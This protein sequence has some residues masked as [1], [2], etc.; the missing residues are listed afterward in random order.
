METPQGLVPFSLRTRYNPRIATMYQVYDIVTECETEVSRSDY[1][2][3][4][5]DGDFYAMLEHLIAKNNLWPKFTK[6]LVEYDAFA[7]RLVEDLYLLFLDVKSMRSFGDLVRSLCHFAKSQT[8]RTLLANMQYILQYVCS[9]EL[10]SWDVSVLQ[11]MFSNWE[12]VKESPLVTKIYKVMCLGIASSYLAASGVGPKIAELSTDFEAAV[13]GFASNIDFCSAVVDMVTFLVERISLCWER[14]SLRPLLHSSRGYAKWV[15]DSYKLIEDSQKMH[16]PELHGLNFHTFLSDLDNCI[17]EGE[18]IAQLNVADKRDSL[19]SMLCKLRLVRSEFL[20]K[21]AAGEERRAPFCLLVHGGSGVAK[22][23]FGRIMLNHFAKMYGLKEGSEGIHTRSFADPYWSNLRSSHWGLILDDIAFI[24]PNKGNTDQSLMELLQI[25]GN[26]AFCPP[27][28]ELADKGKVPFKGEIVIG[29]TNTPHLNADFW[30][31]NP[32]AVR[33][34]FPYSVKLSIKKAYAHDGEPSLNPAK[35]PTPGP[36]DYHDMWNIEFYETRV[37]QSTIEDKQTTQDFLIGNYTSIYDYL[38]EF[39]HRVRVFRTQQNEAANVDKMVA[40]IKL[41]AA[42]D[43]PERHCACHGPTLQSGEYEWKPVL[44]GGAIL[45]A[46]C[47]Y[48]KRKSIAKQIR[49]MVGRKVRSGVTDVI[50]AT[51][52]VM[53][54]DMRDML[55]DRILRLVPDKRVHM[56]LAV[57]SAFIASYA[58]IR[59]M[60]GNPLA[61]QSGEVTLN[62]LDTLG[63]RPVSPGDETENFYHQKDDYRAKMLVSEQTTSWK[64][65][66]W[67]AVCAKFANSVVHLRTTRVNEEG[68]TILTDGRAVCLGGRLYV[69]ANHVL[70]DC[71]F[72]LEVTREA[73][74]SGLT[75]NVARLMAPGQILRVPHREL[76]FFQL[77]DAF[78]CRD[79]SVFMA[80]PGFQTVCPGALIDRGPDGMVA[81]P[82]IPRVARAGMTKVQGV[83]YAIEMWSYNLPVETFN[84]LC[85]APV[86]VRSPSGPVVVGLHIAGVGKQGLC[87]EINSD[88]VAEAKKYFFPVFSPSPPMLNSVGREVGVTPLHPKSVFRYINKGVGRVFGQLTVPRAQPKTK[89]EP[90]IFRTAA[91][92]AGYSVNTGA[93]MM[94]GKKLWR[95]AVLPIVEQSCRFDENVLRICA[96]QFCADVWDGLDDSNKLELGKM[97]DI[98]TAINGMP[99]MKYVDSI[100]RSTSAGFPW[101]KTKKAVT[102]TLEPND[103][104]QD[105]IDVNEEV[106]ERI[107]EMY[108]RYMRYELVAPIF[109]AHPKDE[110]LPWKKVESEAT[111]IMNGGPLDWSILVRMVYLPIV[112]VIQNNKFLF[113]SMPGAV[114][115]SIEWDDMFKFLTVFGRDRIIA[116]D[117]SKFDKRMSSVLILY[118]FY[119]LICLMKKANASETQ[120]KMAWG[121]AYDIACS[122]CDFAGDLVQFLGSN[123][124]G[125]PLTVIINC[126]V[127]ILYMMYCY[128]YL[129]PDRE[130]ATFREKVRLLTYGDDNIAGSSVDWFN[131]TSIA[132]MLALHGVVYTMA[133]KDSESVPFLDISETTFLKRGWRYEAELDAVVCPIVAATL[134]KMMTTWVPSSTI[135]PEAQGEEIIR[136]V[137]CEY[138]WYGREEFER[139]KVMLRAIFQASIPAEYETPRTFPTWEDLVIRWKRGSGLYTESEDDE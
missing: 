12:S 82:Q 125:H 10:Q 75:T 71:K 41:C 100:N 28:A 23:A 98:T 46:T 103:T 104:W 5:F 133:D 24:N 93:P 20:T 39:S 16:N 123:P 128:Y 115:Q 101:Y 137:C 78:D 90:T 113:M 31:S 34:R 134:D 22:T 121:I 70:P 102:V 44:V 120:I 110:P 107:G 13:K 62:V 40:K 73:H 111:R 67:T 80:A 136:N 127:N 8:Q 65:L 94:R 19:R 89:V 36:G 29:T 53:L 6:K 108:A 106:K 68:K 130:V 63:E 30:F 109:I 132:E 25:G 64:A 114:A 105:P 47:L 57:G 81:T 9:F 33:R 52:D 60:G 37:V 49:R 139:R 97:L 45:G 138:F 27:Q 85:G 84:G 55:Q 119:I 76:A 35:V 1:K 95:Q 72:A 96:D 117:Y 50:L 56:L 51:K 18:D 112:R 21:R 11:S 48:V 54:A 129:N 118:A 66:E 4:G 3:Q 15:D 17:E 2:L 38:L 26:T 14:K 124:S 122:F 88:D 91:V 42:C 58:L 59:I 83:D 77:L 116:G 99:G 7:S 87:V 79:I 92:D 74:A 61:V 126:L 135:S 43:L 32:A 69:T 86:V 131:H